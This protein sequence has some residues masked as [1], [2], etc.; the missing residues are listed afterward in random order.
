M[1][2]G[3]RKIYLPTNP[4]AISGYVLEHRY[5]A[6]GIIGRRLKRRETIHH[7]NEAITDNRPENLYLFQTNNDHL[8]YHN[9]LRYGKVEEITESNLWIIAND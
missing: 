3:Y 9:K 4:N 1:C 5:I 2:G 8:I 7:I 6:E